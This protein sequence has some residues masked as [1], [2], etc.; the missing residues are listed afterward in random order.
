MRLLADSST[1]AGAQAQDSLT[2]F[3]INEHTREE[4]LRAQ[5]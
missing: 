3:G 1:D 2:T 4:C 5:A